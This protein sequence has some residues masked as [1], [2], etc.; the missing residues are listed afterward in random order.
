EHAALP[1]VHDLGVDE[2]GR[3]HYIMRRLVGH[4]LREELA[5]AGTDARAARLPQWLSILRQVCAAVQFAHLR[6][7]L[8]LDLKPDNIVLGEYGE[9]WIVDWGLAESSEDPRAERF[10]GTPGYMAP[11]RIATGAATSA[12]D[13]FALGAILYELVVGARPFDAGSSAEVLERNRRVDFHRGP[14]FAACPT[15]LRQTI[16]DCLGAAPE[17]R[18]RIEELLARI[19]A[20]LEGR[21]DDEAR[22]AE[23]SVAF[24][25]ALEQ[26][27][28]GARAEAVARSIER[29]LDRTTVHAWDPI[30]QKRRRWDRET[31]RDRCRAEAID[32]RTNATDRLAFALRRDPEHAD[33]RRRLAEL[34]REDVLAAEFSGE[35]FGAADA[36]RR[37]RDL[38]RPADHD[39]LRG[40]GSLR[41][42]GSTS[43]PVVIQRV[44]W[45]D[46]L[47]RHSRVAELR[48]TESTRL[49]LPVGTYRARVE[50][51]SLGALDVPFRVRRGGRTTLRF[52][53]RD[54]EVAPGFQF[55]AGGPTIIGGDDRALDA[56]PRREIRV[57]DFAIARYPVTFRDYRRFLADLPR[58]EALRRLP[59][60]ASGDPHPYYD[61]DR[62][63]AIRRRRGSLRHARWPV[64]GIDYRDACA[65]ARWLGRRDG[66]R[67]SLPTSEQWEK[68]ARGVD[69]RC[70]PWG[71]RFDPAL[72]K[73]VRSV[74]G[75][76]QPEAV[77]AFRS[78][79]SPYGVR[80]LAGGIKEWCRSWFARDQRKRLI[81][82]GSWN[83]DEV[84]ARAATRSGADE[85][86]VAPFLGF[87]LVQRL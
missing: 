78:D 57:P 65:Y 16:A 12:T 77:G 55:V 62:R 15:E 83:H 27:R 53:D 45:P 19:D 48:I 72:A 2:Q 64:F 82:G 49:T 39:F 87:R 34:L 56:L 9:L 38:D 7:V 75:R 54:R 80:D 6:G 28:G 31:E 33:A 46:F 25:D 84:D 1:T 71:D 30:D 17:G 8:H 68:A 26:L 22:R 44:T 13:V 51:P 81:K 52:D 32:A 70:F 58:T 23:A 86:L 29:E 5:R 60:L 10:A 47:P 37:L 40:E 67:Y 36:L 20:Y 61:L 63:Y 21:R 69:G 66:H 43:S 73:S 4:S 14:E 11:E 50:R 74:R 59:R 79:V 24:D 35:E 3:P 18:P 42:L 76:P 41:L 85:S